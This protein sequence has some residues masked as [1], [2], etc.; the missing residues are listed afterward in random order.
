MTDTLDTQTDTTQTQTAVVTS[1]F[2]WKSNLQPD[3]AN[4]PTM[5]KFADTKEGFNDSVKS[6]LSLQS[7]M[8]N[9]RVPIPKGPDDKLAWDIFSKA[10]GIPDTAEKYGLSDVEVPASMKGLTF[11]KKEFSEIAH[12][13]KFTP[14]QT[15][16]LWETFTKKSMD[17]YAQALK[18]HE[19]Q[20]TNIVNGLRGEWG[21]AY[22]TNVELGQMVINKFGGDKE[23]QDFIAASMLKD[24]RGI[25]FLVKLGNQFAENKMGDFGIKKFSL[26]PDE[27]KKEWEN[28]VKDPNDPYNNDKIDSRIRQERIDYVNGLISKA[29]KS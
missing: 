26:S 1:D 15:K 22:Q 21:D 13:L 12:S 20:M 28:I 9:E 4:S 8:G 19:E 29:V 2:S 3:Y 7:L 11:D 5:Q 23:T 14:G 10:M 25:K 17:T 16:T 24:P 27:A 6:H 18:T